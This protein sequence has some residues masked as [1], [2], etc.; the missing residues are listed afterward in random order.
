MLARSLYQN[1]LLGLA[2]RVGFRQVNIES[3]EV[4]VRRDMYARMSFSLHGH[5]TLVDLT[6]FLY[7]F[8]S[9]GHLQQI[10]QLDMKPVESSHDLDVSLSVEALS[11][12]GADR[13]DH[14]T[15]E[16]GTGL[17]LAGLDAYRGTIG[18]RNLFAPYSPPAAAPPDETHHASAPKPARQI[19]IAQYAFVTGV[20][21]VDGVRQVWIQDRIAGKLWTLGE[22]EDFQVGR[23]HG[24]VQRIDQT[25][26]VVVDFD[27][28][29][30]RLLR[31]ENLRGGVE[32]VKPGGP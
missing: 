9:A 16:P 6:R 26:D 22:G 3:K 24:T 7:D 8:Y 4:E 2:N 1:W 31:G 5:V 27:G 32:L 12:P 29:R 19:D 30:R 15:K 18:K 11:L 10:R 23:F 14:L 17:Q 21:E 28:H 20:T 13:K 25:G